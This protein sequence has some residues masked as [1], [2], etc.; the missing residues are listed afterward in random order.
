M[1]TNDLIAA[2]A[3]GDTT[4]PVSPRFA[5]SY[6]AI[7]AT[8]SLTTLTLWMGLNEDF[9]QDMALPMFWVKLGFVV[10]LALMLMPAVQI[11]GL[12]G[13]RATPWFRRAG[14]V[15]AAVWVI[16]LVASLMDE[17][18]EVIDALTN[19]AYL[20]CPQTIALLSIPLFVA[21]ILAMRKLA[22]TQLTLAGASVGLFSGAV[23]A[24]VYALHCT[25][26]HP[27]FIAVWYSVG[28]LIPTWA[29]ALLGRWFLRW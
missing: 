7:A 19:R 4:P 29:G 8:V 25:G 9:F 12:P 24:C 5:W 27:T 6:V 20:E 16:C 11:V 18:S 1:R 10:L 14:M 23:A 17:R 15:A 22:P 3:R 2:L 21:G 26:Y 13:R 28:I